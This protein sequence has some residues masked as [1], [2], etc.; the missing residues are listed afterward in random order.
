MK[1][2]VI[3]CAVTG[4]EPDPGIE[5]W[6]LP[7]FPCYIMSSSCLVNKD[8]LCFMNSVITS[9]SEAAGTLFAEVKCS[10]HGDPLAFLS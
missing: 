9:V 10:H 7:S 5:V 8:P 2:Q 4:G 6:E 3:L 1:I